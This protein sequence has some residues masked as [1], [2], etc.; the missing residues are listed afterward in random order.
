MLEV[1][2]TSRELTKEVAYIYCQN[3]TNYFFVAKIN[4]EK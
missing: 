1:G 3:F 2:R 4:I